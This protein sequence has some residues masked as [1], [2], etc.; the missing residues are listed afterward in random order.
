MNSFE[1]EVKNVHLRDWKSLTTRKDYYLLRLIERWNIQ[2][3]QDPE[4]MVH[5]SGR[6]IVK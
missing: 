1:N 5:I 3:L 4:A 2:L 6:N